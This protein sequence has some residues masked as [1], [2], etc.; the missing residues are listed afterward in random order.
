MNGFVLIKRG[1]GSS[2]LSLLLCLGLSA[3]N[4]KTKAPTIAII[5][6]TGGTGYW[7]AFADS[8]RE[9]AAKEG[10]QLKWYAPQSPADY[11]VQAELLNDAIQ[12]HVDGIVLAPSH[13]LVLAEGVRRAYTEKIPVVIVH[14]PIAVE[15]SQYVTYIGCSDEAIGFRAAQ[16]LAGLAGGSQVLT[17]GASPTL[18]S[19]VQR[20]DSLK[21]ALSR[22]S[23]T[24]HIVDSRYSLSDWARARQTTLDALNANPKIDAVFSSDDFSSHGV[25]SAVQS[26][27]KKRKIKVVAVQVDSEAGEALRSGLLDMAI[28]C[29]ASTEGKLSV[30]AMQQALEKKQVEKL[31]QTEIFTY[32]RESLPKPSSR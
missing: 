22:F 32:T 23:P 3:C 24:V 17:I 1:W 7:N 2:T 13:Q 20:E 19:T 27:G 14:G 29:D 25:V 4:A 28:S 15:P 18:Q 26:L 9:Q 11:E 6:S 21:R 5:Q 12:Y 16:E 8:V 10:L 30:D 31:I